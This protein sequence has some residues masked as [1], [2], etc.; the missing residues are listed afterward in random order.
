MRERE[1]PEKANTMVLVLCVEYTDTART[2][3]RKG[4]MIQMAMLLVWADRTQWTVLP[5]MKR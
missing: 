1:R 4:E 5:H 3:V 2:T